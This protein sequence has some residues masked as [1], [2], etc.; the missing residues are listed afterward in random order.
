MHPANQSSSDFWRNASTHFGLVISQDSFYRGLTAEESAHAQDYNF[1]H[2]GMSFAIWNT[3]LCYVRALIDYSFVE[4]WDKLLYSFLPDA[5][6]TE[7]L[8]E[9]MGQLKRAQPVNVPIYDFKKHRRCSES[10]RKVAITCKTSSMIKLPF[11]CE[12]GF[13]PLP[14]GL[15]HSSRELLSPF[16]SYFYIEKHQTHVTWYT[17]QRFS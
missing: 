8:L 4:M 14:I 5:F 10:F 12:F 13:M 17:S 3:Y 2:P 7:Q 6:D 1:D 9:C 16:I 15:L 11:L